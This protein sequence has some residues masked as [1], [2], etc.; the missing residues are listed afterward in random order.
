[1]SR[2]SAGIS[3]P[4]ASASV[5]ATTKLPTGRAAAGLLVHWQEGVGGFA[6]VNAAETTSRFDRRGH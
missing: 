1:M 3:E 2:A 5:I 6:A 4:T